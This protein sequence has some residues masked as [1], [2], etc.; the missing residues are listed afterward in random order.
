M[1]RLV[2]KGFAVTSFVFLTMWGVL[3][4]TDLKLF[5]AFNPIS[6]ALAEFELTD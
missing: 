6:Q 4:L 5:N 3:K 2:L 1:K